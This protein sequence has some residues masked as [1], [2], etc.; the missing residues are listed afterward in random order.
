M[1][2]SS[3]RD[4]FVKYDKWDIIQIEKNDVFSE[5]FTGDRVYGDVLQ[6]ILS[7]DIQIMRKI[8]YDTI[9]KTIELKKD[10]KIA[11]LYIKKPNIS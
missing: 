1:K 8:E 4:L 9:C 6:E 2:T 10:S 3:K 11:P 5:K 7:Q